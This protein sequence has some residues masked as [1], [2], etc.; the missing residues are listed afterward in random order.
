MEANK[1]I[2]NRSVDENYNI[3]IDEALTMML[4]R[5]K[6]FAPSLLSKKIKDSNGNVIKTVFPKI[7]IDNFTIE[8]VHGEQVFTE[9]LG[10]FGYFE[11]K[12]DVIQGI[13]VKITTPS[14]NSSTPILERAK[15]TEY[16]NNAMSIMNLAIAT[17]DPDVMAKAKESIRIDQ[18]VDWMN[19]AFGYDSQSL[20][21][22]TE[23]DKIKQENLDKIKN[24]KDFIANNQPNGQAM[25]IQT[26][27]PQPQGATPTAPASQ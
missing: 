16:I 13:G 10:K 23:K 8:K 15:V 27:E 18:L 19:D 2:R 20:K 14:T 22:N 25:G 11:L 1:S 12:P 17:Q 26:P 21:S 3:G 5:I 4:D 9:S 7:R 6:Q 24:I